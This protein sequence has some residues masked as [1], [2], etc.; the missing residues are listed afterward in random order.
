MQVASLQTE[1][2][3]AAATV[4][5]FG[6]NGFSKISIT[7]TRYSFPSL[8]RGLITRSVKRPT[9]LNYTSIGMAGFAIGLLVSTTS[10]ISP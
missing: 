6:G 1:L 2:S 10:S 4:D 7:N 5:A 9:I 3:P 8:P